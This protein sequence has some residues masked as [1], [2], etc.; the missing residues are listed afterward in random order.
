MDG[1]IECDVPSS[2]SLRLKWLR[3]IC[4]AIPILAQVKEVA[5]DAILGFLDA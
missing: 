2:L 4:A 3:V 5:V 1:A